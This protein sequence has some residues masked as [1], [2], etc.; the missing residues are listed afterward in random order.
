MLKKLKI[1]TEIKQTYVTMLSHKML[2][3]NKMCF[4]SKAFDYRANCTHTLSQTTN[5]KNKR[6]LGM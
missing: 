6:E 2:S 1:V 5:T 4:I 3:H